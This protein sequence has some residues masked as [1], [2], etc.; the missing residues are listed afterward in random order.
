MQIFQ[1]LTLFDLIDNKLII[2]N[3]PLFYRRATDILLESERLNM[4]VSKRLLPPCYINS[5]VINQ[6][7]VVSSLMHCVANSN[8]GWKTNINL[9]N[10]SVYYLQILMIKIVSNQAIHENYT[11]WEQ[12]R[13]ILV[14]SKWSLLPKYSITK[15]KML[16]WWLCYRN[17]DSNN[18]N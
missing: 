8:S 7:V 11:F 4:Q 14:K 13:I 6:G 2:M 16:R 15:K 10:S 1:L 5:T 17:D 12:N 18:D 3:Y 9:I